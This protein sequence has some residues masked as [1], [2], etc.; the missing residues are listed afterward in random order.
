M[1]NIKKSKFWLS[2]MESVSDLGFRTLCYDHGAD[3][4]FIEMIHAAALVRKNKAAQSLVDAYDLRIPTGIQLFVTKSDVLKECLLQI[5]QGIENKDDTFSN[6]SVIDLNF[7]CPSPEII[8]IGGGPALL[9]RTA[10]MVELLIVLK[11]YSPL[12][13][14]IKIRLGMNRLE[15]ENKV[16]LNIIKIVND[17][18]LDYITVHP[19][20][21]NETSSAPIDMDA[22]QEIIDHAKIPVVGNGFITNAESAKKILQN[23][24]ADVI[25]TVGHDHSAAFPLYAIPGNVLRL[26]AHGD[27]YMFK[28]ADFTNFVI[29]GANYMH[30]VAKQNLK[31]PEEVMNLGITPENIST[32]YHGDG[33]FGSPVNLEDIAGIAKTKSVNLLDIDVDVLHRSFALP[34]SFRTSSLTPADLADIIRATSPRIVGLFELVVSNGAPYQ[35]VFQRRDLFAP[36][37]EAVAQTAIARSRSS[38]QNPQASFVAYP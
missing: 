28:D 24:P 16:Y 6:L 14:G 9:K 38:P 19:K 37:C 33:F 35:D 3:L 2:P 11:K 17:V 26:D 5:K 12:P 20:L 18:N 27:A 1:F 8:K 32:Q 23:A 10:K 21:A 34:H 29:S 4:T 36:L 30:Y 31:R 7:G 13:C 15:K 25:I 22:L